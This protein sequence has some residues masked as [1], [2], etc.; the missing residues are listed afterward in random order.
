MEPLPND[1]EELLAPERPIP[2]VDPSV[3]SRMAARIEASVGAS[4]AGADPPV[5]SATPNVAPRPPSLRAWLWK[6]GLA[7]L[8]AIGAV[9]LVGSRAGRRSEVAAP[10]AGP[11][12]HP[13]TLPANPTLDA[14]SAP[15]G[16]AIVEPPA[17]VASP[18]LELDDLPDAAPARSGAASARAPSGS[19][20]A[21]AIDEALR[22]ERALTDAAR[23]SIGRGDIAG[24]LEEL[25]TATAEFPTGRL[26]Q[27]REALAIQALW[28]S[29]RRPE[30]RER[31]R[32]FRERY[33]A[34]P[35][36][37]SIEAMVGSE[38]VQAR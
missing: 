5:T 38:P 10:L 32:T 4:I 33:P 16:S 25:R 23:T 34:S 28:I 31:A 7:T 30:A 15:A 24:A 36:L 11:L 3:Q 21:N 26:A 9:V 29:G 22:R 14:H 18:Y 37:H 19:A 17:G 1:L 35:L 27:E 20:S 2:S 8:I 6:V 13:I 12:E